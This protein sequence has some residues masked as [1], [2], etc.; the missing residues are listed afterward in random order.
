[1]SLEA[2]LGHL[3]LLQQTA[4]EIASEIGLNQ[5]DLPD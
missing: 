5:P 4:A 1:M 2:A 3:P